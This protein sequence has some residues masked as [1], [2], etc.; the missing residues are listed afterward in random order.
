MCDYPSSTKH[1]QCI[2]L[3]KR[4]ATARIVNARVCELSLRMRD[5]RTASGRRAVPE[6]LVEEEKAWAHP[7]VSVARPGQRSESKA[8]D[9]MSDFDH[10]VDSCFLVS[11]RYVCVMQT[12]KAARQR[13][14]SSAV[15]LSWG[16]SPVRPETLRRHLSVVLPL[17]IIARGGRCITM[18][19][20]RRD[21]SLTVVELVRRSP[22]TTL[23][24][25]QL[26]LN[27]GSS[28][29]LHPV[30]PD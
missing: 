26:N 29:K 13:A 30:P 8:L 10:S 19:T 14:R 12:D 6:G 27:S 2:A 20:V 15:P 25:A 7:T 21:E 24:T 28:V 11:A 17:S 22:G 5:M 23:F 4:S 16:S 3:L 18:S 9:V 1:E